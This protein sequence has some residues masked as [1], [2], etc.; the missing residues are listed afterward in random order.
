MILRIFY[1]PKPPAL[2]RTLQCQ[3]YTTGEE[4]EEPVKFLF[5][6]INPHGQWTG[7]PS[8]PPP[9]LWTLA[10]R[11]A[12]FTYTRALQ[13]H[14]KADP[15]WAHLGERLGRDARECKFLSSYMTRSWMRHQGLTKKDASLV[16]AGTTADQLL[17]QDLRVDGETAT[18][19]RKLSVPPEPALVADAPLK[20]QRK[21]HAGYQRWS[22]EEL[23]MLQDLYPLLRAARAQDMA[24]LVESAGRTMKAIVVKRSQMVCPLDHA[25][26]PPLTDADMDVVRAAIDAKSAD[27]LTW[28]DVREQLPGRSF[29]EVLKLLERHRVELYR[30]EM[31]KRR[32]TTQYP[33]YL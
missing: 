10:E 17:A 24:P 3:R 16:D 6:N 20:A 14:R 23:K 31:S 7:A 2:L 28:R 11:R 22:P 15:D 19:L 1:S 4:S 27:D 21:K 13:V 8:R 33:Q 32:T 30:Y 25:Q 12:L 26:L 18:W 5:P 9:R 29:G